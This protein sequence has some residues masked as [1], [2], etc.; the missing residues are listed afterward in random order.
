MDRQGQ[1]GHDQCGQE[2][3]ADH[4]NHPDEEVDSGMEEGAMAARRE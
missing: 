1:V 2:D 3:S 4:H